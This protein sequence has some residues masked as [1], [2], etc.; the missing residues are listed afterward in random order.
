MKEVPHMAASEG[1]RIARN[2]V[3]LGAGDAAAMALGFATTILVTDL[4]GQE[5]YGLLLGAQRFVLFLLVIAQFGLHPLLVRAVASRRD[6][7]GTILGTVLAL[8]V[9]CGAAFLACVVVAVFTLDYLPGHLWLLFAVAAMELVAT[10]SQLL[11]GVCEGRERMGRSALIVLSRALVLFIGVV[12]ATL[13][14]G[15]LVTIVAIYGIGRG[16]E[17]LTAILVVPGAAPGLRLRV[18]RDRLGP[19]LR[20]AVPFVAVGLAFMAMRSIDVTMLARLSSVAETSRYGAALNFAD[21]LLIVPL[22]VQRALLPAFSRLQASGGGADVARQ[23]MIVFSAVMVPAA[24]GLGL[25]ADSAVALYPSGEFAESARVLEILAVS[26]LF[27]GPMN[28]CATFLTGSGRLWLIVASYA[29]ALPV[30]A[31]INLQLIDSHGA[32]GVAVGTLAANLVLALLLAG[33][34]WPLGL[35]LPVAAIGRQLLAAFVMGAALF[36]LRNEFILVP[37]VG[38][39]LVYAV[40]LLAVSPRDALERRLFAEAWDRIRRR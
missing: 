2:S 22:L 17:L 36:P 9:G 1:R 35:R 26:L 5:S 27:Y 32:V 11:M 34:T 12:Y 16:C 25:L 8:R 28:V 23:T 4:L 18:R 39:L 29:L 13:T 3:L 7:P 10:V 19:T 20:E 15:G 24:V 37:V 38:G 30:Q 31:L 21:L 14:D 40:V 33:A 6:E